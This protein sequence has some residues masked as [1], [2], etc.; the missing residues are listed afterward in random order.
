LRK[1]ALKE[2]GGGLGDHHHAL[3]DLAPKE[4]GRRGL[5]A[6]RTPRE[7][8]ADAAAVVLALVFAAHL[9]PPLAAQSLLPRG[10]GA[11]RARCYLIGAAALRIAMP[12]RSLFAALPLALLLGA[13]VPAAANPGLWTVM[14]ARQ[15]RAVE[16]PSVA[17]LVEKA[18]PAA[19]V[20][21]AEGQ[22][23]SA[24]SM[25][26]PPGHPPFPP[27]GPPGGHGPTQGQ[28]SG[29]LIHPSGYALTNHHVIEGATSIRVRVG[30]SRAELP[31]TLVGSDE[32]T[33]VALIKI[34]GE[35]ADWPVM[36][37]GNS[38]VLRVGDLVVAIGNPFGLQQSVSMGIISARGRR[39]VNPSG[40]MG[41]YDFL[42][43][44]A[45]IN[46]GNSGG[47]L[48]NLA[49]EVVGM[50]TAVNAAA[51]GIGFAIPINQIKR[52]LPQLK[53]SGRITRAWIGVG[54][55]PVSSELAADFGLKRPRGALVRQV[56]EG[57]PA[58]RAGIEAGDVILR[59]G[60]H[61]IEDAN[62]LPLIAGDAGVNTSV[63]LTLLREGKTKNLTITLGAHPDN[64]RLERASS[65]VEKAEA[66]VKKHG[67]GLSVASLDKEDRRRLR[68]AD[69]ALGA[70]VVK[71]DFGSAAF[72]AGLEP[73]DVI[74]KI[75]GRE[76]ASAR[77]LEGAVQ[78]AQSGDVLRLFV[79]RGSATLFVAMKKP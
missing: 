20:V 31:A 42:Q 51:Q 18:E 57:G 55:Q 38:D 15:R 28:G 47:P 50:N 37:L 19:L 49:G 4:I 71:V 61:D 36:P 6:A 23:G 78:R 25:N 68:F 74:V 11:E 17:P 33:D 13:A 67:L 45:S 24:E 32:K 22:A 8:D 54:I 5:A 9:P 7:D 44:D 16:I 39:D 58:A 35:R 46:L 1:A 73:D 59:F 79:R 56:V 69:G 29:F 64:E 53:D 75:N 63:P 3:A 72:E 48:L 65:K 66:K 76:V 40:R 21:T 41:L 34:D 43:T 26:L 10:S 27:F 12:K 30:G 62:E 77:A 70:R 2:R 60:E 14:E 52:M